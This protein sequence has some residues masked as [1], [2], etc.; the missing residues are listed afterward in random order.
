MAS[1][2]MSY[3]RNDLPRADPASC[4]DSLAA[5]RNTVAKVHG[6]RRQIPKARRITTECQGWLR[7][8]LRMMTGREMAPARPDSDSPAAAAYVARN[9]IMIEGQ[10]RPFSDILLFALTNT[11]PKRSTGIHRSNRARPPRRGCCSPPHCYKVPVSDFQSCLRGLISI[12]LY[13]LAS[14]D[15]QRI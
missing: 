12:N 10:N 2:E 9:L 15:S 5:P 11:P 6:C 1:T 14:Y 8:R 7:G 13:L 4:H 3:Q